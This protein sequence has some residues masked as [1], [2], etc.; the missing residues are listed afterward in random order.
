MV[1]CFIKVSRLRQTLNHSDI[2]ICFL[3]N[4]LYRHLPFGVHDLLFVVHLA[5]L[6]QYNLNIYYTPDPNLFVECHTK[7]YVEWTTRGQKNQE[8]PNLP[9]GVHTENY[10]KV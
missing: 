6:L 2:N 4:Q 7:F 5:V 1:F 8:N 10:G 9:F 3:D